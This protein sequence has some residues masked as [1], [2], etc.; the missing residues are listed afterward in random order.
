MLK[1]YINPNIKLADGLN[2]VLM[3]DDNF[4]GRF[5]NL[6][7]FAKTLGVTFVVVRGFAKDSNHITGAVYTPATRSEHFIG[8]GV[9]VNYILAGHFYNSTELADH[10]KIPAQIMQVINHWKQLGYRWGGDFHA[11]RNGKIDD[12][13]LDDGTN[14]LH[15]ALYDELYKEY[16]TA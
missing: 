10:S 4:I 8:C 15:P 16:H 5:D 11:D 6:V 1:R 9:D 14:V 12:V 13:H 3:L 7:L 2:G